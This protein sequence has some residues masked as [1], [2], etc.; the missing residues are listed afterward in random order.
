MTSGFLVGV[1]VAWAAACS[2]ANPRTIKAATTAGKVT[3][4]SFVMTLLPSN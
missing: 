1:A 2:A 3:R 4:N